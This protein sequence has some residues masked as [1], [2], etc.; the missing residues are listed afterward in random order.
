MGSPLTP[1]N[2][3]SERVYR[4]GQTEVSLDLDLRVEGYLNPAGVATRRHKMPVLL[5]LVV[6]MGFGA[7]VFSASLDI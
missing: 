2:R 4:V 6:T 1:T 7:T 5:R 3:D